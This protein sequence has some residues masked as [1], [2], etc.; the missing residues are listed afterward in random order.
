MTTKTK[1]VVAAVLDTKRA[2]MESEQSDIRCGLVASIS[3]SV[4][5]L[6]GV[7]RDFGDN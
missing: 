5:Y 4:R 3:R 1:T 2:T 6:S 7:W